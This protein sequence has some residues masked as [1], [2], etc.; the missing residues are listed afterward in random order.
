MSAMTALQVPVTIDRTSPIPLYHQLA[1]QL[2]GAIADGKLQPGDPFENEV[3]VA[4]RL[5]LSRPT[6]RRAIQELVDQG[7]LI[8]RRGHGTT[9]SNRRVHRK[10]RL[11]SLYDDLEEAGQKPRTELLSLDTEQN[12]RAATSLDLPVD[13][14]LL[15][16]ARLRFADDRPLAMMQ[17]WLPPAYADISADELTSGGLYQALRVRGA[18]PVVAHQSIGARMPTASERRH[19]NMKASQPLLTMTRMAF[20]A[21]GQAIEFG[22]HSYRAADYTIDLMVDE[23]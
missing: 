22:D 1:E 23:R 17:N 21:A 11:T 4:E 6:V 13:T 10:A 8:R 7:L 9:V 5:Q 16:V 18:R 15:Y 3:S 12:E 14:P 20:D 2:G 19:L